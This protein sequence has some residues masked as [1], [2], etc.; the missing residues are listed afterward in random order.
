MRPSVAVV[1]VVVGC[2]SKQPAAPEPA[3][4]PVVKTADATPAPAPAPVPPPAP[5]A[6]LVA[7]PVDKDVAKLP[8]DAR[9]P[10]AKRWE[11]RYRK[12]CAAL[13]AEPCELAGDLDGD[14]AP[15]QIFEIRAKSGTRA[16]IA[17]QWS[18]GGVS[19]IGAGAPSR[20]LR[21]EI[22]SEGAEQQWLAVEDDLAFITRW[23]LLA[24]TP[25][26]FERPG[27]M[28][29]PRHGGGLRAPAGA[30]AGIWLDGG[31][32]GEVLYWDGGIWRRL[33]AGF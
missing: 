26:G 21:T 30:G 20:Q 29:K 15:E 11:Q 18:K 27:S 28:P 31:D 24:R 23:Q 19:I 32:A 1:V 33:V 12:D 10:D 6:A 22:H 17:V 4:A 2:S 13:A 14:G 5:P 3:P 16:G 7:P 8:A 25:D 9:L